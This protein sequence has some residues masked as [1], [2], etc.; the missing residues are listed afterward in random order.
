[1]DR[2]PVLRV[3]DPR[4]RRLRPRGVDEVAPIER[5]DL[6]SLRLAQVEAGGTE[7]A[8]ASPHQ[9]PGEVAALE[10]AEL[11]P[12]A[13]T[14]RREA[15]PGGVAPGVVTP[16]VRGRGPPVGPGVRRLDDPA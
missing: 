5:V 6:G 8:K 15:D 1:V 14:G 2:E 9:G 11:D 3:Q 4:E 10:P 16:E 13:E 7:A 12:L